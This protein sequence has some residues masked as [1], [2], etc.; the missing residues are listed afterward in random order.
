MSD[1]ASEADRLERTRGAYDAV[2]ETY[3]ATV[4][5][6]FERDVVG[7][8]ILAAFA[9]RVPRKGGVAL[10]VLDVGCGP[11]H[12]TA[13]LDALG[14]PV[15]GVDLSA[16][17]VRTARER[18]P[19]LRFEVGEMARLD[20]VGATLGGLVSWWSLVHTP[21]DRLPSVFAEF[22][23]VLVP[24]GQL[25]L[26]FYGGAGERRRPDRPY[27]H[28]VDLVW[29]RHPAEDVA[30]RLGEAGFTVDARLVQGQDPTRTPVCLLAYK[31]LL[32][33][34]G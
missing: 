11:G 30:A 1:L 22:H 12:V 2:A 19:E 9:E 17:M 31:P 14:L 33:T 21:A 8:A 24:G 16:E 32:T 26:G 28:D 10:P 3:A 29:H 27:G 34:A 23:R 25:L 20:R 15:T 4:P 5:E 13:H 6:R 7:R 18:H